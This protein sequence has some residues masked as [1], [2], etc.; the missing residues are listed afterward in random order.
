MA[1]A[2]RAFTLLL[3]VAGLVAAA[4]VLWHDGYRMYAVASGSML[5]NYQVGDLV[6]TAPP[7]GSYEVGDVVGQV[8]STIPK[9]GYAAVFLQQ[10]TGVLSVL[11]AMLTMVALWGL[12]FPDERPTDDA[13]DPVVGGRHVLRPSTG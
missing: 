6:V 7:S 11:T 13:A 5:P 12:F 8:I 4:A 1:V 9:A 10:P 2:R 3:I